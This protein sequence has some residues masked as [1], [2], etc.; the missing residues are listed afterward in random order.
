MRVNNSP[1]EFHLSI[2]LSTNYQCNQAL[3]LLCLQKMSDNQSQAG[4]GRSWVTNRGALSKV[5]VLT[6]TPERRP[7][8]Q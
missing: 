7:G 3:D 5:V 8:R 6:N 1:M 2:D 4:S